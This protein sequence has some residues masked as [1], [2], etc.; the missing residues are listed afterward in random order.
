MEILRAEHLVKSYNE[1]YGTIYALND[2]SFSVESG[3]II[4]VIGS[5]GSGKSTLFHI[6][7]SVDSPT[8]GTVYMND[9]NVFEQSPEELAVFR[10]REV[11]IIYQFNNLLPLLTVRENILLPALLDGRTP[12]EEDYRELVDMLGLTG[13]EDAFP[14][15][16]SGGQQQRVAIGRTLINKPAVVL[17]DEPTGNLDMRNTQQ[18][19]NL[20]K[21]CNRRYNQ[22][23]MMITHDENIALQADRIL[24]LEDGRLISDK[25]NR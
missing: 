6:L 22:T 4:A 7:G 10:R 23:I 14:E 3:E 2:V 17:S 25:R 12:N 8:S 18:I 16:L 13:R 24:T 11:G 9:Q 1:T 19:M 5:S 21:Y 20:F 15:E